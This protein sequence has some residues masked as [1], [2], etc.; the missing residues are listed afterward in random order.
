MR[1]VDDVSHNARMY[2][3]AEWHGAWRG[4][5]WRGMAWRC[6]SSRGVRYVTCGTKHV[7]IWPHNGN[8]TAIQVSGS[9]Q[10]SWCHGLIAHDWLLSVCRTASSHVI[11]FRFQP[12]LRPLRKSTAFK[13]HTRVSLSLFPFKGMRNSS[14]SRLVPFVSGSMPQLIPAKKITAK[15]IRN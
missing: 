14:L 10:V 6:R 2:M 4:V 9:I 7:S 12:I 5:A 8:I 15:D 13:L 1:E 3:P 11:Y